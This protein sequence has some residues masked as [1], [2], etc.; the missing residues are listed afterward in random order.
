MRTKV[1]KGH[2]AKLT[3]YLKKNGVAWN[4]TGA[5]IVI[6]MEPASGGAN[7]ITDGACVVESGATGEI[8]Y[9][10]A[11]LDFDT[12][13]LYLAQFKVTLAAK[14]ERTEKFEIDVQEAV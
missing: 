11:A 3:F 13:D 8:S 4:V 10:P 5:T 2:T 1:Y 12:V 14:D 7:K 9:T 6:N